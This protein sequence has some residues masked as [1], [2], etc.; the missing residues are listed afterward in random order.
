MKHHH[1]KDP[2]LFIQAKWNQISVKRRLVENDACL[3]NYLNLQRQRL[4]YGT[5]WKK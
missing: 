4:L 3:S 1:L 5:D 2:L